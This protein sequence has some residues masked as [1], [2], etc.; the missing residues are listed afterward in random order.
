MASIGEEGKSATKS[1]S[2]EVESS[3]T[4]HS[5]EYQSMDGGLSARVGRAGKEEESS[6]GD[7]ATSR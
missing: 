1:V 3:S 6:G 5:S 4:G 2:R 7:M